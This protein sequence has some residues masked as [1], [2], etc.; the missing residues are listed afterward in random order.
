MNSTRNI[1]RGTL[2]AAVVAVGIFSFAQFTAA[3]TLRSAPQTGLVGYWPMDSGDI[4]NVVYDRSGNG[5]HAYFYGGAT[6]SAQVAGIVG[7][8][9][10]F[11]GTAQHVGTLNVVLPTVTPN[12]MTGAAWVKY[13]TVG[14]SDYIWE[15]GGSDDFALFF[16][17]GQPGVGVYCQLRD[18]TNGFIST[19]PA[20]VVADNGK[21]NHYACVY[22]PVV[23]EL[24]FYMNGELRATTSSALY[25][26]MD[27]GGP[28]N[29]GGRLYNTD[30]VS[31][32]IDE[33]RMYNRSLSAAEVQSI[34]LSRRANIKTAQPPSVTK[35]FDW[36]PA[37]PM[38]ISLDGGGMPFM[39]FYDEQ[40]D[41]DSTG[42]IRSL[43]CSDTSCNGFDYNLEV[44]VSSTT[45]GYIANMSQTIGS[46]GFARIV[47]SPDNTKLNLVSCNNATCT[48]PT[49]QNIISVTNGA[50]TG[51]SIIKGSD[52]LLGVGFSDWHN[53]YYRFL[54][55]TNASCTTKSTNDINI[56]TKVEGSVAVANS[57]NPMMVYY[58]TS[59]LLKYTLCTATDCNTFTTRNLTSAG[60][61]A[62][63]YLDSANYTKITL[64]KNGDNFPIMAFYSENNSLELLKCGNANCTATSSIP[65]LADWPAYSFAIAS[66]GKPELLYL[67]NAALDYIYIK[68]LKCA[69]V[70]CGTFVI[71]NVVRVNANLSTLTG[72][73]L[74]TG[75]DGFP[76]ISY[77]YTDTGYHAA[78]LRCRN[79]TCQSGV[80]GGGGKNPTF[81]G[82]SQ[83]GLISDGLVGYWT[84]NGPD[85]TDKVYD[86]SGQGNDGYAS[87]TATSTFKT[88]GK[89]GQGAML[90]GVNAEVDINS[91]PSF[92]GAADTPFSFA[93][94]VKTTTSDT[95]EII[96]W[97]PNRRCRL[98]NGANI[99]CTVSGDEYEVTASQSTSVVNDGK[100][101][102]IVYTHNAGAQSLYF[103]GVL[104]DVGT[105][106]FGAGAADIILGTR[107]FSG[108]YFTGNLDEVRVYGRT[109]TTAE[110]RTLYLSGK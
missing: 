63:Y 79:L 103:D 69:D 54:H 95:N 5:N 92:T 2:V 91:I 98:V 90:N 75:S 51:L 43:R 68:L 82:A 88:P 8:G 20:G 41:I 83:S 65:L 80:I 28:T 29:F 15:T 107:E 14:S 106:T 40:S 58:D 53:A 93:F 97:G 94:W 89:I 101:H 62:P 45:L 38:A 67:D 9:L 49:T 108:G 42:T 66:D 3:A 23:N 6:S 4:S 25:S 30:A 104:E 60:F 39:T 18:L 37:T 27:G 12:G 36:F 96:S 44:A 74:A 100:W 85:F 109:L 55:C 17:Y 73:S 110:V 19:S 99:G 46:D 56:G 64:L 105:D 35:V 72:L 31:A 81:V 71:R 84:F 1:L 87:G 61:H 16:D 86:R 26:Q 13:N 24:Q 22:N 7:Q 10:R 33:V 78:Y 77:T 32:D 76:I 47:Y 59:Q 21:Y 34:F 52:N 102:Y 57:G 50:Y 11:D 48:A 70:S